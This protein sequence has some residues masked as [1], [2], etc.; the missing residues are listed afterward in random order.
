MDYNLVSVRNQ[1][2]SDKLDDDSFDPGTVD[3]F[4]NTVQRR[5]FNTYELPFQENVFSGVLPAEQRIFVFPKDVQLVQAVVITSPDGTQTDITNKRMRYQD[6][7]KSYPTP[8]NNPEGPII[9][10]TSYAGKMY[11]AAPTDVAY[12]MDTFY[13]MKPTKLEQDS[14][15]PQ[16]PEEFQELLVLGAFI[17][18][19]ERNEDYDLAAVIK[20]EYNDNLDLLVSRYGFRL[21]GGPV[22]MA[23]PNRRITR[24]TR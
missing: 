6:F 17:L 5:I 13:L 16:I 2:I 14:D 11:T 19:L 15:V 9:A 4:I 12:Q 18:V 21:G 10:W 7:V 22:V 24:R 8:A 20:N 23:Q 3:R 1:V